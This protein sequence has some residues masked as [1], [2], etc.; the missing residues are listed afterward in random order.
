M[1]KSKR[2]LTAILALA[3][4]LS[5]LP[6]MLVSALEPIPFPL[7]ASDGTLVADANTR[8][9]TYFKQNPVTKVI[10]ATVQVHHGTTAP[11]TP[12]LVIEGIG[13]NISFNGKVAPWNRSAGSLYPVGKSTGNMIEY[14]RYCRALINKLIDDEYYY[15]NTYGSTYI[16]RYASGGGLI[17]G[18]LSS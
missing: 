11:G 10:T 4:F 16:E 2:F 14:A 9:I 18:K 5:M 8:F 7:L 13:M 12:N 1:Q 3:M 17:G 15:F 6:V